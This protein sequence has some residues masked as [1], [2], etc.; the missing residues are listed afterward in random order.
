[1]LVHVPGI[2]RR[3]QIRSMAGNYEF[4]KMSG[5]KH[6]DSLLEWN[7][8]L[9]SLW[10]CCLWPQFF[11]CCKVFTKVNGNEGYVTLVLFA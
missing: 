6:P 2:Q 11:K 7:N 3:L 5:L 8:A 4:M 1:M 10:N 9:G